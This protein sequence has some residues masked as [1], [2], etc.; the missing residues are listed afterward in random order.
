MSKIV[1]VGDFLIADP[2]LKD[3]SFSRSVVLVCEK[4]NDGTLGFILNKKIPLSLHE[5]VENMEGYDFPVMYGGPVLMNT[6]HFVHN[7]PN[8]IS[9]GTKIAKDLYWG[10]DFETMLETIREGKATTENLRLFLGQ[11]G[12]EKDQLQ[13][14][15]DEK[16]WLFTAATKEIVFNVNPS[17]IWQNAVKLL[18]KKYYE[19]INYPLDP[20]LN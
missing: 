18:G 10:G 8:I 14:E 3:N 17:F 20:S 4:D 1:Q 2:F 16:S 19:L 11:S 7:I 13:A 12:W 9:N 5:I 6:L 15:I